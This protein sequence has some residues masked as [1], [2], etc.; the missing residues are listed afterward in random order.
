[1]PRASG[2]LRH[3]RRRAL[4]IWAGVRDL[5]SIERQMT[6]EA[7]AGWDEWLA[8]TEPQREGFVDDVR[9]RHDR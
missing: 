3:L 5:F 6:L 7:Q 2:R 8:E 4:E 9:G 1:M